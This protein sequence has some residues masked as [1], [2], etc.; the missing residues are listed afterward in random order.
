MKFEIA[1]TLSLLFLG[2]CTP[3]YADFRLPE[4]IGR[5]EGARDINI[6][7]VEPTIIDERFYTSGRS[8]RHQYVGKV[9][10]YGAPVPDTDWP[11]KINVRPQSSAASPTA[12]APHGVPSP[13]TTP[14]SSAAPVKEGAP[15]QSVTPPQ[16]APSAPSK[17]PNSSSYFRLKQL[18]EEIGRVEA[19]R[20][21]NIF[22]LEPSI[23]HE[24]FYTSG[25]AERHQ[26]VGNILPAGAPIP[27]NF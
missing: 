21:M 17:T 9:L 26:Q 2:L 24:R 18:P 19:P 5:V 4:E 12:A 23:L 8:E 7:Q 13:N 22:A 1:A 27:D 6:F 11:V 15:S 20:D 16:S 10:P 25:A 14:A 3:A